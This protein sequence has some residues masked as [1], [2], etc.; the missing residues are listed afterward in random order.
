MGK[1]TFWLCCCCSAHGPELL[2][3]VSFFDLTGEVSWSEMEKVMMSPCAGSNVVQVGRWWIWLQLAALLCPRGQSAAVRRDAALP[4]T[5]PQV[6]AGSWYSLLSG[7]AAVASLAAVHTLWESAQYI[8]TLHHSFCLIPTS[9]I[10]LSFTVRFWSVPLNLQL[11]FLNGWN[12]YLDVCF[13]DTHW[14]I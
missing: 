14:G 8:F 13:K 7:L 4:N 10:P 2:F 12:L 9:A 5:S 11:F 3:F 6:L 1:M